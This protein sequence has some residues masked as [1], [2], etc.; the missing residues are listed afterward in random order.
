M[1]CQKG[2][3][4]LEF[5]VKWLRVERIVDLS[6]MGLEFPEL[7]VRVVEK[8]F[9]LLHPRPLWVLLVAHFHIS[10]PRRRWPAGLFVQWA[11]ATPDELT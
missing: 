5:E 4:D 1:E 8:L 11:L 6:N 3:T 7:L 2:M 10:F 9:D